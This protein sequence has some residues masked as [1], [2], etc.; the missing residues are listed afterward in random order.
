MAVYDKNGKVI[1]SAVNYGWEVDSSDV[2]K[3]LDMWVEYV[4]ED[5]A[6]EDIARAMDDDTLIENV[7]WIAQQWGIGEE[8]EEEHS[9]WDK[10]EKAKELMGVHE[11]FT[12][13]T[14]A[15]GYDELAEDLA[16]IFRMNDFREWDDME[17]YSSRKPIK[18]GLSEQVKKE[19]LEIAPTVANTD[20]YNT[21]PNEINA[22]KVSE[23][24]FDKY[25]HNVYLEKIYVEDIGRFL[26]ENGY[27]AWWINAQSSRKS[28]KSSFNYYD[29]FE[30]DVSFYAEQ[31]DDDDIVEYVAGKI[32]DDGHPTES[33]EEF[34][35]LMRAVH[36]ELKSQGYFK[37]PWQ[38]NSSKQ[39]RSSKEE[40]G[41]VIDMSTREWPAGERGEHNERTREMESTLFNF[42]S[43][44]HD[45][46]HPHYANVEDINIVEGSNG[47]LKVEML[48]NGD[49]KHD[50][51][52]ADHWM[53]EEF[54]FDFI[55]S[56]IVGDS[57]SDDYEAYHV[58]LENPGL[59]RFNE[60]RKGIKSS[61]EEKADPN[62]PH[63]K[64]KTL[65]PE[66]KMDLREDIEDELEALLK[67]LH[68]KFDL[69]TWNET[70]DY[71]LSFFEEDNFYNPKTAKQAVHEWYLDTKDEFPDMFDSK[72]TK[73]ASSAYREFI[74]NKMSI[75]STHNLIKS[76][77]EEEDPVEVL[78]KDAAHQLGATYKEGWWGKGIQEGDGR[79]NGSKW[80]VV[81]DNDPLSGFP[82]IQFVAA[83]GNSSES[84]GGVTPMNAKAGPS[85]PF[86]K[87]VVAWIQD[88]INESEADRG[89]FEDE[90]KRFQNVN[91]K[92]IDY[93]ESNPSARTV[94][95]KLNIDN[96]DKATD[97]AE[98]LNGQV[99][100]ED[101]NFQ[102]YDYWETAEDTYENI[103]PEIRDNQVI[104]F[105]LG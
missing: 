76:S 11:L 67:K 35:S 49:W 27:N 69:E 33:P 56:R 103:D 28:I 57:D 97:L 45:Q 101:G 54:G 77:V 87:N 59:K 75:K 15:A 66:H 72:K 23:I 44:N 93:V 50:H 78:L 102:V 90:V 63:M 81:V 39:V 17:V 9:A 1:K 96:A 2:P 65:D 89:S 105:Y 53:S 48:I 98:W 18:S 31:C 14:Q 8:V 55:D 10:Y 29:G 21:T 24:L 58:Y 47:L 104:I 85:E 43:A 64:F 99:G 30:S 26:D 60:F 62:D 34:E 73:I 71:I 86:P 19:I 41:E 37:A 38:V 22:G 7:E 84:L 32:E 100:N 40:Q 52:C 80:A 91:A 36:A 16:Y 83:K 79:W 51:L 92:E 95:V 68:V 42:F 74:H 46:M 3:A 20:R 12:N 94:Y 6:L 4:G 82:K 61:K 70:V 25:G 88:K 13:L 5:N